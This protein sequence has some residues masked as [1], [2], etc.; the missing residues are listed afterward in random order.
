[1]PTG[2][3]ARP[4]SGIGMTGCLTE[5]SVATA[6]GS[7]SLVC[8]LFSELTQFFRSILIQNQNHSIPQKESN[9]LSFEGPIFEPP[10]IYQ[11]MLH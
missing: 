1:M 11:I 4:D 10:P 6:V 7:T 2:A 3:S 9:S 5:E 8:K